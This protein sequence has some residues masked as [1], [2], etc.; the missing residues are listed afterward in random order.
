MLIDNSSCLMGRA[1]HA[2]FALVPKLRLGTHFQA[3][4]LLCRLE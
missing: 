1:M 4:L 3:K 2:G